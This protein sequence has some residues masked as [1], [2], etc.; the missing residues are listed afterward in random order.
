MTIKDASS[1][2]ILENLKVQATFPNGRPD[3][4][5]E[6]TL[7]YEKIDSTSVGVWVNQRK[8][9]SNQYDVDN[10]RLKL[11]Q[12]P[13]L[14]DKIVVRY[15]YEDNYKNIRKAPIFLN[16]AVKE[17]NLEV[18]I[19]DIIAR[20]GDL[21]FQRDLNK[22]LSIMILPHAQQDDYYEVERFQGLRIDVK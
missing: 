5:Q 17:E 13:G 20:E 7:S 19:N 6:W 11:K 22:D 3:F 21:Y 12:P 18:K 14:P 2:V 1:Q 9:N 4:I 8:L 15:K 10:S 16:R